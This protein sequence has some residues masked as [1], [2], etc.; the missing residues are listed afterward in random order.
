MRV[1][2]K[3][4]ENGNII[5]KLDDGST[6]ITTLDGRSF[7]VDKDGNANINLPT[8][9]K[10]TIDNI[11]DLKSHIIMRDGELTM[12]NIELL[13]GGS[14][15]I[16]FTS[17]GELVEFTG[18]NIRQTITKENDVIIKKL[19]TWNKQQHPYA[20]IARSVLCDAA[21]F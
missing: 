8:I 11:F 13:D 15:K 16:S 21:I 6:K 9:K 20:V 18:K 12:H 7:I 14:V 19:T 3:T 2:E 5:Q 4:D 10:V 1:D 17:G